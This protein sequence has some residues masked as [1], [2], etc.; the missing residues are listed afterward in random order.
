MAVSK[1]KPAVTEPISAGVNKPEKQVSEEKFLV[2]LG[3]DC[4][5]Y[6]TPKAELFI[7]GKRYSM[8]GAKRKELFR[9]ADENGIRF[10]YDAEVIE[11]QIEAARRK[12]RRYA[13]AEEGQSDEI[14]TATAKGVTALEDDEGEDVGKRSGDSVSI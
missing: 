8:S 12:G 13:E 14:D 10:F 3:N 1:K 6:M 4:Q 11:M 7:A 9:Y 5:R 2:M